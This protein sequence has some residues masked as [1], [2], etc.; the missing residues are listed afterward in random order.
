MTIPLER[1]DELARRVRDSKMGERVEVMNTEELDF[2]QA[3]LDSKKPTTAT[4]SDGSSADYYKLPRSCKQLQDLIAFRN[5]NAQMGE[6]F[7][8]TFR[9]GIVPHSPKERDLK[10]I[11]YYAQAELARLKKY[12]GVDYINNLDVGDL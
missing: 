4:P 11:I 8:A 9:Y 12:E 2:V 3:I 10:K 1:K 6:I 5:M 7:R